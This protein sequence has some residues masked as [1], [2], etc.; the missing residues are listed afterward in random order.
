V[1]LRNQGFIDSI[2]GTIASGK[3]SGVFL[4]LL[5]ARGEKRC[6]ELSIQS[7]IVIKIFRTSTLNFRKIKRYI[8][9]DIR[10]KK[11][12]K[13]TREIIKLWVEK[14]FRNLNR[15]H[16][17]GVNVPKPILVKKNVL[18]M[19]LIQSD[20]IPS[21]LLK[22]TPQKGD[23]KTLKII[24]E[25]IKL[26][27]K[28]AGLVHGDLSAYNILMRNGDPVLIDMSQSILI[29]HPKAKEFLKRDI[30]NILVYFSGKGI[31]TPDLEE[32]FQDITTLP[33]DESN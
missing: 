15:S 5:G 27:Y 3:E 22:N 12:S 26:L 25:Q 24:L 7:P 21:P 17:A 2:S 16:L 6:Q 33:E 9:G 8:S 30:E 11:H 20:G 1:G 10:F 23:E 19:E 31:S 29:S 18:L 28:N 32:V 13:K 4:A 14:E